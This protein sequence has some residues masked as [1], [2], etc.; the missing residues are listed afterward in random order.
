MAI[1]VVG[2]DVNNI[3]ENS[4]RRNVDD[5]MLDIVC[6]LKASEGHEVC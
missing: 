3:D 6:M 4:Q 5:F 2:D 1:T